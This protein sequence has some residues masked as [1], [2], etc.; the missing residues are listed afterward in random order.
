MIKK[1]KIIKKKDIYANTREQYVDN[2]QA[3]LSNMIGYAFALKEETR[4]SLITDLQGLGLSALT[5]IADESGAELMKYFKTYLDRDEIEYNEDTLQ[6][7]CAILTK[8]IQQLF[9]KILLLYLNE[10]TKD[11]L[12]RLIDMHYPETTYV[13]LKNAHQ[14]ILNK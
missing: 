8:G 11:S 2:Y 13:L 1:S 9:L 12:V 7:D 5:I 14:N 3:G 4:A 6:E 10:E